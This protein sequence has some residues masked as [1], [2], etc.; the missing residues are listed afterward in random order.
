MFTD[1]H[2]L[3]YPQE[4]HPYLTNPHYTIYVQ[5]QHRNEVCHLYGE[6]G[7]RSVDARVVDGGVAHPFQASHPTI[8]LLLI[9]NVTIIFSYP[10]TN[11]L[12]AQP[13]LA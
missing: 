3:K 9:I 5:C 11:F 4:L 7:D 10:Y 12:A 6:A 13:Q 1:T 2:A 8:N